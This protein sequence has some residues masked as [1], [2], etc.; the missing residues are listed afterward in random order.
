MDLLEIPGL[1]RSD[2]HE[3]FARIARLDH[4]FQVFRWLLTAHIQVLLLHY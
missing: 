1:Q 3:K 2:Q 4:L